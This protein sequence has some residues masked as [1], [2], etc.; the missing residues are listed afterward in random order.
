MAH[1]VDIFGNDLDR[2][3]V[4]K[5]CHRNSDYRDKGLQFP[6]WRQNNLA[7]KA[8]FPVFWRCA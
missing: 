5:G 4:G 3:Q 6:D 1:E 7:C 8:C 2:E